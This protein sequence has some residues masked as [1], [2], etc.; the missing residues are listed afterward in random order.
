VWVYYCI[1]FQNASFDGYCKCMLKRKNPDQ[2]ENSIEPITAFIN[3]HR[4]VWWNFKLLHCYFHSIPT[5]QLL[6]QICIKRN[7][8]VVSSNSMLSVFADMGFICT[9]SFQWPPL[10]EPRVTTI[11]AKTLINKTI[12]V[13]QIRYILVH[14]D[15]FFL[16]F[17]ESS[18]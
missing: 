4:R 3:T 14:S 6:H 10:P 7:L 5:R 9:E 12:L 17:F 18:S 11:Y 8:K 15:V 2:L 13:Y 1:S 16:K